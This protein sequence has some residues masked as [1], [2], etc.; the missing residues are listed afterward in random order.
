MTC[1][2]VHAFKCMTAKDEEH[3]VWRKNVAN[4]CIQKQKEQK[5]VKMW[6]SIYK[7]IKVK[8]KLNRKEIPIVPKQ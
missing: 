4:N 2:L 6:G 5:S 1:I 3:C 8:G 7:E